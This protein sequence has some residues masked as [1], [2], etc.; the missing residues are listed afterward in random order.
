MVDEREGRPAKPA[1]VRVV[2]TASR[3]Q[4]A[5]H[6]DVTFTVTRQGRSSADAVTAA[7]EAYAALDAALAGAA[8]SIERRTTT[9]L[10][11]HETG[12]HDPETGRWVR[13]G[14]EAARSQTARFAPMAGAGAALR[15]IVGAVPDLALQGP[16]FGLRP[17][18][19]VHAEV[20]AEAAAS[21][22]SSAEAYASGVGLVLGEVLRLT[23]PG[24]SGGGPPWADAPMARMAM[25]A[26]APFD[27]GSG[28]AVL[29]DLTDEDVEVTA[30]IELLVTLAAS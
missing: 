26:G 21:A 14:F 8:G 30:T 7:G 23:E 5:D 22:R 17:D 9:S 2:G 28:A 25:K 20:R 10:S 12:H 29:V 19:P 24:T 27:D 6:A 11:V 4:K 16:S 18:N 13:D 1:T 15:S 3:W